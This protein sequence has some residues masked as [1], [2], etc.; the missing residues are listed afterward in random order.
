MSGKNRYFTGGKEMNYDKFTEKTRECFAFAQQLAGKMQHQELVGLHLLAG[1][2]NDSEG[3]AC[4]ILQKMGADIRSLRQSVDNELNTLPRVTGSG[5]GQVYMGSEGQRILQSAQDFS[6]QLK[7]E[8]LSVEHLLYG[9]LDK[10]GTCQRLLKEHGVTLDKYLPALKEVRGNQRVTSENPE[11][12]FEA[13]AK[14]GKDLTQLAHQGKLDPVIGRETE[15]QRIIQILIRR[16]KNNPVL[17]G[18]PG[19]GKSAVAEG[20]AQHRAFKITRHDN[21]C[22]LKVYYPTLAVCKSTV[23]ENLKKYI[24]HIWMSFFD[25]VKKNNAVWTAAHC[26]C[27]LASL[28]VTDITCRSTK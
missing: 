10:S 22:I 27:E 1:L 26:F 6:E 5:A 14:Y 12:T 24:K 17:I 23:I 25:F 9:I 11:A 18:E 20:L 19:V 13:L 15:I 2:L 3:T 28:I 4:S 16:T 21:D 8:F 7:D